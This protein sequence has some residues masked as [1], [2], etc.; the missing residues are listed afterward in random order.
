MLLEGGA[1]GADR[2]AR[3]FANGLGCTVETHEA[4]WKR[5]GK[6]AGGIRNQRMVDSKPDGVLAFPGGK[7]TEDCVRRAVKAGISVRIAG[8]SDG[9]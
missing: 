3:E 2:F 5:Y 6:A 7:G 4:D 1:R 8:G 9:E